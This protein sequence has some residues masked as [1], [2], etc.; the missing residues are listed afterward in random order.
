MKIIAPPSIPK[1]LFA[2]K[3]VDKTSEILA[4][5]IV[6]MPNTI[7]LKTDNRLP[8][9]DEASAVLAYFADVMSQLLIKLEQ[10]QELSADDFSAQAINYV[11]ATAQA[12]PEEVRPAFMQRAT[13]Y[14]DGFLALL[15]DA[16]N[17][18]DMQQ[19]TDTFARLLQQLEVLA[20]NAI[21]LPDKEQIKVIAT[22]LS[23]YRHA[24]LAAENIG[25]L[26]QGASD[27]L[28][29]DLTNKLT[30]ATAKAALAESG[31]SV[32][33][34]L[35]IASA[36][37]GDKELDSLPFSIRRQLLEQVIKGENN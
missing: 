7:E 8:Q 22:V 31:D 29:E 35:D 19:I 23:D 17:T 6:D 18:A 13:V 10:W 34:A 33:L 36:T 2:K 30:L 28:L 15:Q 37:S 3:G 24:V 11:S 25:I 12:M 27:L 4:Q 21:D 16:E 5:A 32:L 1:D 20:L 26:E 14:I 9:H